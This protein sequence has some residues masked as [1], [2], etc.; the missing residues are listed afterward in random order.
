MILTLTNYL[1]IVFISIVFI[2]KDFRKLIEKTFFHRFRKYVGYH[3]VCSAIDVIYYFSLDPL[4]CSCKHS[5][6]MLGTLPTI[7]DR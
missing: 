5:L 2:E 6:K 1:L 3:F 4:M 7:W